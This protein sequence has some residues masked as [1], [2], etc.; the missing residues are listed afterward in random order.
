MSENVALRG[1]VAGVLVW[2]FPVELVL[3]DEPP[4]APPTP[5]LLPL[6]APT[7][8]C[9]RIA[10]RPAAATD[11]L[12]TAA[13]PTPPSERLRLF[14]REEA[15]EEEGV[16]EGDEGGIALDRRAEVMLVLGAM[17]LNT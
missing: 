16:E 2:L 11:P 17:V 14:L 8:A 9:G 10:A 3:E 6:N 1:D 15:R 5:L 7:T 12:A 4:G 13:A